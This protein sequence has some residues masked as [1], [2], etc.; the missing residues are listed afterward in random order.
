M[1]VV[2]RLNFLKIDKTVTKNPKK[3]QILKKGLRKMRR[4]RVILFGFRAK[5]VFADKKISPNGER[6]VVGEKNFKKSK[7][8]YEKDLTKVGICGR[9]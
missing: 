7:K 8:G 3:S 4:K 6:E 1:V 5:L 2:G 9:I